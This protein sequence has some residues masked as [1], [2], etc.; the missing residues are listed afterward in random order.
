LSAAELYDEP[1]IASSSLAGSSI[2]ATSLR[3]F[4]RFPP[5][6]AEPL[7]PLRAGAAIEM[8]T[9][10]YFVLGPSTF[11]S[12]LGLVRG[13]DRTEPTPA[14]DWLDAEIDVI[15]PTHNERDC[16]AMCPWRWHADTELHVDRRRFRPTVQLEE[17]VA[18]AIRFWRPEGVGLAVAEGHPVDHADHAEVPAKIAQGGTLE[19][20]RC[21]PSAFEAE[22]KTENA[23]RG[24]R[25][26][27]RCSSFC[28]IRSTFYV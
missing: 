2:A 21:T 14:D 11:L 8:A 27:G 3:A 24:T 12:L 17:I 19:R 10:P 6:E 1:V 5:A 22:R 25:N 15:I 23:K 4:A 9:L 16:I 26:S 13:S 18:R 7:R 28:V 20:R